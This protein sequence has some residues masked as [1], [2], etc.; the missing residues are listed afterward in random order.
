MAYK[1]EILT[2]PRSG[3]QLLG[4]LNFIFENNE[5]VSAYVQVELEKGPN[6]ARERERAPSDG[7]GEALCSES[8]R[9]LIGFRRSERAGDRGEGCRPALAT[10]AFGAPVRPAGH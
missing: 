4:S 8:K 9:I 7:K 1:G 3:V 6:R 5:L 2:K 10:P